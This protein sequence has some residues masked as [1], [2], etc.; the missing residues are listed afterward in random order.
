V[1]DRG[2]AGLR[3]DLVLRRHLTDLRAATRTQVQMWIERGLVT[4]NGRPVRRVSSRAALGDR[5]EVALPIAPAPPPAPERAALE[6]LYEDAHLLAVNKP[7]G[8]VVHPTHRHTTGTLLNALLWH[9]RDWPQGQRP[10]LIGRLDKQTSGIVIVAKSAA[11]HAALQRTLA[12]PRSRKDYLAV[13]YGRLS[14]ARGVVDLRLGRDPL[15][16]RRVVASTTRGA[17]SVTRY[18]RLA[19]VPAVEAGLALLR[20]TLLT[21][22]THQIRVH[23]AASG[24]PI[25]GDPVY[26]EPRWRDIR[27]DD[28]AAACRTFARQAL[29]AW[30]VTFT[31]PATR[32]TVEIPAG[33][34]ADLASLL[35]ATGLGLPV[36]L[37]RTNAEMGSPEE[38]RGH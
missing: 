14:R 25:V 37:L 10:S 31:H 9:A 4:V 32:E 36:E 27:S 18:E 30:R 26:G 13:V 5:I 22:R 1:A 2:D 7:P 12:D 15:D 29:H 33:L 34:P 8:L 28:V 23:L 38:R 6:V 24:W 35:G 11:M 20:C 17:E 3:L 19:R 16:R 21:G